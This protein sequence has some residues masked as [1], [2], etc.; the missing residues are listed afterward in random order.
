MNFNVIKYPFLK[1]KNF[2]PNPVVRYGI[3]AYADAIQNPK[4][5]ETLAYQQFWEEQLYYI[6][7]GYTTGGVYIPGRFYKYINFDRTQTVKGSG[8]LEYHDY[9]L[10][11]AL[12]IEDIKRRRKNAYV[13]K[14]RRKALSVMTVGMVIDYGYRFSTNYHAAVVA[15]LDEHAQDF[16]DKWRYVD[17]NMTPEFR[18]R[19]LADN[20]DEIVSGWTEKGES[21]NRDMGTLNTIYIRTVQRNPNVLKGKFLHDIVMEESGENELLADTI[22]ASE[23]CLKLGG[24]QFGTFFIYGTGGNMLKGSKDFKHIH[25]HLDAYNAEQWYVPAQV[26]YFPC[27][28]GATDEAGRLVEEVPGL[29]EYPEYARY[30]M[31]D[32]EHAKALIT[33]K[34]QELLDSGDMDKYFQF[35]QNNPIDIKEIFRQNSSNNF[36]VLNINDQAYKI[37]SENKKYS[38]FKLEYK[39]NPVSGELLSP[40]Q[41][42]LIPAKDTDLESECVLILNDGHP[43]QG[44]VNLDVAGI[45]SYDQDQSKNSSSLGAMVVFRKNH[46][47]PNVPAWAPVAIIRTRP[48]HKE[49]F[50]EMCLKLSIYY[51]LRGGV[52]FDKASGW[53]AKHFQDAGFTWLLSKR[54]KKFESPNSKQ[55]EEFGVSL[56]SYTKPKMVAALQS[57]F[58]YHCSK[59]WFKDILDEA[60]AYDEFTVD[61]DY[62]TVDA[63]GIALMKA[64]DSDDMPFND[65]E[66]QKKDPFSY[67]DFD[68]D[69]A[70]NIIPVHRAEEKDALGVK[71][72]WFSRHARRLMHDD[73][74]QNDFTDSDF[75]V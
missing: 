53:I 70:G 29:A 34:K 27:Y 74:S 24:T 3:P 41:V 43:V 12:W 62:D 54:P 52:L 33:K 66:L 35:C 55:T 57:L 69:G 19:A 63:L 37:E 61:S 30:G 73:S 50:Y 71:E 5:V 18:V 11:Y 36:S 48:K 7:N 39:K 40:T 4:A 56:N 47:M 38:K 15:G 31:S 68:E 49:Q 1:S 6:R 42:E 75:S 16:I 60:I 22:K 17:M 58:D 23:D 13:P 45:D 64:I 21:G 67:P 26:F 8:P 14:A 10:D 72:D 44:Y 28:A 9:Q 20:K 32:L 51:N 59:I 2:C 46:N 25:H 65:E